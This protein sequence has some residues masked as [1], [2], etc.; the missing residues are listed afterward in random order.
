MEST[1]D[2]YRHI[3]KF[4][5]CVSQNVFDDATSLHARNGVLNNNPGT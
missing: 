5:T 4:H 2:F 3:F 1:S